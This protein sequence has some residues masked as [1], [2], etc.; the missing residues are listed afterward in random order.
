MEKKMKSSSA[1]AVAKPSQIPIHTAAGVLNSYVLQ[2]PYL[3]LAEYYDNFLKY[4]SGALDCVWG[5]NLA[6]KKAEGNQ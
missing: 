3:A 4:C 1:V 2:N 5:R 6:E